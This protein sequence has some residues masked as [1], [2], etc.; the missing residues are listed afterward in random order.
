MT[1]NDAN[2]CLRLSLFGRLVELTGE[3]STPERDCFVD[4]LSGSTAA[5]AEVLRVDRRDG[6]N[7][8][9]R[10]DEVFSATRDPASVADLIVSGLNRMALDLDPSCLHIHAAVFDVQDR[11]V[12]LVGESGAGKTTLASALLCAGH[13]YLTDEMAGVDPIGLIVR[14]YPKPLTFKINYP[15]WVR[16]RVRATDLAGAGVDGV[17]QPVAASTLGRVQQRSVTAAVVVFPRF[18]AE[19]APQARRVEDLDALAR[20]FDQLLDAGRFGPAAVQ[21]VMELVS[22]ASCWELVHGGAERA[23]EWI[24]DLP[25]RARPSQLRLVQAEVRRGG[26]DQ[27]LFVVVDGGRLAVID[28]AVTRLLLLEGRDAR[29][30]SRRLERGG[31]LGALARWTLRRRGFFLPT[32]QSTVEIQESAVDC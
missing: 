29:R 19:A 3:L 17:P 9:F 13:G 2:A 23:V 6:W 20:I 26:V 16:Q 27:Q 25:T 24:E 32:T 7:V 11:G 15:D 1:N 14:P 4:L 12:L 18:Q 30:L 21:L 5:P 22:K 28:G 31:R 8:V 10:D